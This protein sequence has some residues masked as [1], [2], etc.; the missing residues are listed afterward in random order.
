[1]AHVGK[2]KINVANKIKVEGDKTC[3]VHE[4]EKTCHTIYLDKDTFYE[5]TD[6]GTV[7]AISTLAQ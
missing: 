2:K 3:A 7:H 1:L 6:S 4:K 5:V